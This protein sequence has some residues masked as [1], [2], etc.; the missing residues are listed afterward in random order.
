MSITRTLVAVFFAEKLFYILSVFARQRRRAR[1]MRTS[2]ILVAH[3]GIHEVFNFISSS[4]DTGL[5]MIEVKTQPLGI[6]E[7][8]CLFN[9]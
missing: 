1:K 3:F 2:R 6:D 8:S 7:R 9:V 4:S 5:M